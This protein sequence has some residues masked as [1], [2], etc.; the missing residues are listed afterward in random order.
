MEE[1]WYADRA[2]LRL[3][4]REAPRAPAPRLARQLGRSVSWVKIPLLQVAMR[5]QETSRPAT[6]ARPGGP[7]GG[8]GRRASPAS[9]RRRPRWPPE[10]AR[11]AGAHEPNVSP[12]GV[13]LVPTFP[14]APLTDRSIRAGLSCCI[15]NIQ[16]AR[17]ERARP[18]ARRP[19]PARARPA[20][21]RRGARRER[22]GAR[23]PRPH[24]HG[25]P[26]TVPLEGRGRTGGRR[27]SR[28]R[29]C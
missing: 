15:S 23:P 17:P 5:A 11:P 20:R 2:A 10:A 18:P 12:R 9:G 6:G 22:P 8:C 14:T 16:A 3:A 27:A 4:L 1:D 21:P 19:R 28:H 26:R 29:L 13:S 7:S 25:R 24:P